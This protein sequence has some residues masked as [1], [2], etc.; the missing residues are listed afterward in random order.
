LLTSTPREHSVIPDPEL[1]ASASFY[2]A[3]ATQKAKFIYAVEAA[4][5]GYNRPALFA[6]KT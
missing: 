5:L 2:S 1:L 4:A 3:G 6:L